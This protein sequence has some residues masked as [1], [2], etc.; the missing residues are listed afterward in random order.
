MRL[1]VLN[2]ARGFAAGFLACALLINLAVNHYQ[3]KLVESVEQ[4]NTHQSYLLREEIE[5]LQRQKHHDEQ[6]L[7][8]AVKDANTTPEAEIYYLKNRE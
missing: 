5:E 2:R 1:I 6:A 3:E 4:F 8:W 7:F